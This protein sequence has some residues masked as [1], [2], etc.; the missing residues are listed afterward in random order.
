MENV[1]AGCA[2]SNWPGS[3]REDSFTFTEGMKRTRAS[4]ESIDNEDF[5][6]LSE[7]IRVD[8]SISMTNKSISH[9]WPFS[10]VDESQVPTISLDTNAEESLFRIDDTVNSVK[11]PVLI[12]SNKEKLNEG[13]YNDSSDDS[14]EL[15]NRRK[16]RNLREKSRVQKLKDIII[17]LSELLTSRGIATGKSKHSVLKATITYISEL[18][19]Q[20]ENGKSGDT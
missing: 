9:E 18:E 14:D 13:F 19:A 11:L 17:T 16:L 6:T 4:N 20:L 7:P 1:A 12:R 5:H 10:N 15:N 3:N 8:T 2:R